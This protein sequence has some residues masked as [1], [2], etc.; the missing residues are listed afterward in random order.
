MLLSHV[1]AN[2]NLNT[3]FVLDEPEVHLHPKAIMDFL[4]V[5][6][7]MLTLFDSY[8]IIATHSP[9]VIREMKGRNVY[10]MQRMK[11]GAFSMSQLPF[12]TFG[13]NIASLYRTIFGYDERASLFTKTVKRMVDEGKTFEG[14][15]KIIS[16][17]NVLGL[18]AS[19]IINN[20]IMKRK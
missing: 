5:F 12:E 17:N 9:L 4:E 7:N 14:I 20:E 10:L 13:E 19:M 16:D 3:L 1:F 11:D 2:A 18:N 6:G 15:E 8:S